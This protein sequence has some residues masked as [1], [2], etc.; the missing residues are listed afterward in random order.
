MGRQPRQRPISC[1]LCRVRKLRCSRVFPCSNCTSRGV[2]CQHDG[3]THEP[4]A[5]AA[6]AAAA[7]AV[8]ADEPK[9]VNAGL[10]K[11]VSTVDLLSRLEKLEALVAS[12]AKNQGSGQSAVQQ[13]P[14]PP[15]TE[16][17]HSAD[18]RKQSYPEPPRDASS[19]AS[20]S[21]M[22]SRLQRLTADALWLEA[23]CAGLKLL[24]C[25]VVIRRRFHAVH[26]MSTKLASYQRMAFTTLLHAC[27]R[28]FANT[29][30]SC[31]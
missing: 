25:T 11:D 4:R 16:M 2:A 8:A 30:S 7:A 1:T 13:A 10:P 31:H 29:S 26:P 14:P 20:T 3:I 18:F 9:D 5:A 24:V 6:A 22:V 28:S 23:S 21:T 12:Q 15:A 17:D 27:S 19:L